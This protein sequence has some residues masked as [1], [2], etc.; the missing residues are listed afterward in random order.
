MI[1]KPKSRFRVSKTGTSVSMLAS[2]SAAD[3]AC[4]CEQCDRHRYKLAP[5]VCSANTCPG[6]GDG[7][8]CKISHRR[9][10]LQEDTKRHSHEA[11]AST[12]IPER[13]DITPRKRKRAPLLLRHD[14]GSCTRACPKAWNKH[15]RWQSPDARC[16][17][18]SDPLES[19]EVMPPNRIEIPIVDEKRRAFHRDLHPPRR[20]THLDETAAH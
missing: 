17:M 9:L 2:V 18:G 5:V 11:A 19:R 13:H 14:D 10:A 3:T 20:P 16:F 4:G 6:Q 1:H 12:S 8:S 7:P 15:C